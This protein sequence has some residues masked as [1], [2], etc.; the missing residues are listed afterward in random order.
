MHFLE[1]FMYLVLRFNYV[2]GKSCRRRLRSFLIPSFRGKIFGQRSLSDLCM[3]LSLEATATK[4]CTSLLPVFGVF[5]PKLSVLLLFS[6]SCQ[7][8]FA[9]LISSC[10]RSSTSLIDVFECAVVIWHVCVC[11]CV[12][13]LIHI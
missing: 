13:S 1:E 6:S 3:F 8:D 9:S 5:T 7:K 4:L 11:V 2:P 10:S 12:L